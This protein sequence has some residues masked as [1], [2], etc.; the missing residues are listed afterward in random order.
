MMIGQLLCQLT[1]SNFFRFKC[2][3]SLYKVFSSLY[4]PLLYNY[5]RPFFS[6]FCIYWYEYSVFSLQSEWGKSI[7]ET[8]VEWPQKPL[9]PTGQMGLVPIFSFLR[10]GCGEKSLQ[11]SLRAN[12]TLKAFVIIEST[13]KIV[14]MIYMYC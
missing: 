8:L 14:C 3:I 4:A 9:G 10:W 1:S 5:Y 13:R 2:N 11:Y 7:K 6:E 12:M